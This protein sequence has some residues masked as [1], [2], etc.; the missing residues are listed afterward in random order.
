MKSKSSNKALIQKFL[1]VKELAIAGVSRDSRK[2]GYKIFDH[3]RSKGYK[4]YLVHPEAKEIDGLACYPSALEIPINVKNLLITTNA[5]DTD[6]VMKD[7]ISRGFEMI[8]VQQKSETAAALQLAKE[9]GVEIIFG[10]CLFIYLDP[11]GGHAVH[12]FIMRLFGKV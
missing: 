4:M 9:N 2:F 8:W 7:A 12:R 1:S 5:N 6:K 10:K 3:L 11:K